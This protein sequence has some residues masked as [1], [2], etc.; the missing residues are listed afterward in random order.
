MKEYLMIHP[1]V[2]TRWS[3]VRLAYTNKGRMA[4]NGNL[5]RFSPKI[6][7]YQHVEVVA[8]PL[9]YVHS[10]SFNSVVLLS[11]VVSWMSHSKIK[12][13]TK[14]ARVFNVSKVSPMAPRNHQEKKQYLLEM[15]VKFV[16][17]LDVGELDIATLVAMG[18]FLANAEGW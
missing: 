16:G 2:F 7:D 18:Y 14:K 15:G 4:M 1:E 8:S 3:Y 10:T 17:S 11:Y 12:T 9:S 5:L 13:T 6:T